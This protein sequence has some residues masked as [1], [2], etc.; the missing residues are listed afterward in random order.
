LN[1]INLESN[2]NEATFNNDYKEPKHS[3]FDGLFGCI[4]P[5]MHM[6]S[7]PNHNGSPHNKK[8]NKN[9]EMNPFDEND[10]NYNI[11]FES[12]TDLLWLGSGA[13][14]CVFK[15]YLNNE[16]V[17][18][19]K[20]KSKEEVT[21][22][23]HLMKLDHPNLVKFKGV[24]LNGNKFFCIIME[25]CQFGQLY[26]YLSNPDNKANL[27]PAQMMDW[28]KQIAHGMQYLHSNKIVHRDLK[29][30]K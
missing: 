20:V 29:S 18:I 17:A 16:E 2:Y 27:R 13:Q 1:P 4:K 19:K 8:N 22:I 3:L 6:W 26:T 7:R 24:S 30:P 11:P 9:N 28:S 5:L 12:L 23:K 14:G 21:N 10:P 25:F 15:G